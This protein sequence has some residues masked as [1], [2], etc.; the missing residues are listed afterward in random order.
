MYGFTCTSRSDL[1]EKASD[2]LD[3]DK[4]I[5]IATHHSLIENISKAH[6]LGNNLKMP[7]ISF[8]RSEHKN[9]KSIYNR[10]F[11]NSDKGNRELR[12]MFY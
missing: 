6:M 4:I 11:R 9:T 7:L 1:L 8:T 5:A 10:A 3:N 2:L 12:E